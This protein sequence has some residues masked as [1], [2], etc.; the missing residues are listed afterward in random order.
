MTAAAI[1]VSLAFAGQSAIAQENAPVKVEAKK[2]SFSS[3][4]N[5]SLDKRFK[6]IGFGSLEEP[7]DRYI[8]KFKDEMT[9][10]VLMGTNDVSL[11]GKGALKFGQQKK[12]FNVQAAKNDVARAGGVVKKT[13]KKHRMMAAKLDRKALN[14]L[15][16]N[17]NIESIEIDAKRKPMA[18]TTPYGYTMVQ[19][20]Q[21]RASRL[22]RHQQWCNR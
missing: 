15:R 13:L 22:T 16:K 6:K 3:K 9:S 10:E 14:E 8:V 5:K 19:A 2:Q 1:A 21:F 11:Q 17:P 4:L 7:G 12:A 20:N 18:Q